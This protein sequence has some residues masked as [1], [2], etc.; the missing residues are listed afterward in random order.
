MRTS[1]GVF[2]IITAIGSFGLATL[3]LVEL[4][5]GIA[6][7]NAAYFVMLMLGQGTFATLGA[8]HVFK[9]ADE[10]TALPSGDAESTVLALAA[11]EGG[12]AESAA[13]APASLPLARGGG[14][15]QTRD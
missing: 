1:W 11:R 15:A 7:P 10:T 5:A 9:A 4:L 13:K 8:R 14:G 3:G 2:C 12:V 6:G